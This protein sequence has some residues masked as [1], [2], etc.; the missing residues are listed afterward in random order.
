MPRV[1]IIGCGKMAEQHAI[2]VQT[3]PGYE[4]VAV[5]DNEILMA[6]QLSDHFRIPQFFDD[7]RELLHKTRPDI[8]HITTPPQSH[9]QLGILAL[10]AGCHTFI[11]KP[12]TVTAAQADELVQLATERRLKLTVGHNAQFTPAA[13]RARH[14]VQNNFL[15]GDPVH[16]ESIFCY[17]LAGPT[18]AKEFLGNREHWIHRLPGK[19]LHNIISHG[20]GQLVEYLSGDAVHVT[21]VGFTSEYLMSKGEDGITDE[22]RVI[23]RDERSM[24][25][26]FTFSSQLSPKLHQLRLFGKQNGLIVDDD[27][28]S[29]I[30]LNGAGYRSYLNQFVPPIEFAAQNLRNA[31]NNLVNFLRN[32]LHS[33]SGTRVLIE[34]FYQAIRCDGPVPISHREIVLTARIMDEIFEQLRNARPSDLRDRTS[35]AGSKP[36]VSFA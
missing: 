16:A 34:S 1:A 3:I 18:F 32:D 10:E 26:Y 9:H 20:I 30:R 23:L 36:A 21:A 25:G 29:V 17:D 14:L 13:I 5:C 11:E 35:A 27:H 15:G 8:V 33:D 19:L 2:N 22:L 28:Q 31:V 12:F 7:A 4:I 6:E 24:T